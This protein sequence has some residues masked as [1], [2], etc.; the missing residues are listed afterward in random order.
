MA[1]SRLRM[2]SVFGTYRSAGGCLGYSEHSSLDERIRMW[3]AVWV[4]ML[5]RD[6]V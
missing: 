4:P 1:F 3:A 5:A 2:E 6:Y